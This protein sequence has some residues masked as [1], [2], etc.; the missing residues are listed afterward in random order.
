MQT[1]PKKWSNGV[2]NNHWGRILGQQ[3]FQDPSKLS[4]FQANQLLSTNENRYLWHHEKDLNLSAK[5]I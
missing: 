2:K 4:I 5:E 3:L 1:N